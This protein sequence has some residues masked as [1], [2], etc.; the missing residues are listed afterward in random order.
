[1]AA[2]HRDAIA[3]NSADG[4]QMAGIRNDNILG[5]KRKGQPPKNLWKLPSGAPIIPQAVFDIVEASIQR[6]PFRK[7]KDYLSEACR[8][9]TLKREARR[10]AA[11]LK[12]LQ[13]QMESFSSME[14]TRRNF[15]SMGPGGK[16]RLAR[17]IEFAENLMRDLEQL[18]A[19][20]EETVLREQVKKEAAELEQDFVNE[21]YFPVTKLLVPAIEKAIS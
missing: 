21:C 3:E 17:R 9:W 16:A 1:M 13:L 18:K 19:L 4:S 7:R 11:L 2:Q 10:G 12:R 15:A 8:Y 5:D 6:F 14:L 20:A